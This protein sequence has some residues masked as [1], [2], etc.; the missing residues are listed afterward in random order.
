[1]HV[2]KKITQTE[3][4]R[5]DD[6]TKEFLKEEAALQEDIIN[7]F[8]RMSSVI[9][10]GNPEMHPQQT[11]ASILSAGTQFLIKSA[12]VAGIPKDVIKE[13]MTQILE[14]AYKDPLERDAIIAALRKHK[15]PYTRGGGR[16]N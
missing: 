16:P 3:Y 15:D 5:S 13:M 12:F 14:D 4:D 2:L 9:I 11:L 6:E 1:M 7:E 10:E 8:A